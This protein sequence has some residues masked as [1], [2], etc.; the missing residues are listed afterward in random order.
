MRAEES[1]STQKSLLETL[2]PP[3]L[4]HHSDKG[5]QF[6]SNEYV[7]HL[8]QNNIKISMTQ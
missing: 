4:I 5:L 3:P 1:L 2:Q 6:C 7:N 8:N